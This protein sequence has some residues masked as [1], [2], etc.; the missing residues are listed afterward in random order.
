MKPMLKGVAAVTVLALFASSDAV[1]QGGPP[2]L[3]K[4]LAPAR[5][6]ARLAVTSPAFTSGGTIDERYTQN[7]ENL[8]PA[9]QW[10]RPPVGTR[11]YVV[12]VADAGVN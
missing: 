2:T 8:S 3:A 12:L 5:L 1:G 9:L 11:S 10:P 4:D 6:G 7:G